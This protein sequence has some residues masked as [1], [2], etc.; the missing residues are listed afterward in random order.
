MIA[1]LV[2]GLPPSLPAGLVPGLAPADAPA[3]SPARA[4]AGLPNIQVLRGLAAVTVLVHHATFYGQFLRGADRPLA[5]LDAMMGLWGV[6]VFFAISGFLMAGLVVRDRPFAFLAHRIV[7][8]FPTYL[9]VV[10]LF[11]GLFAALGL[12]LGGLKPLA[13]SLA[14]AGARS[15]PLNVEWTLV[16]E[17]SFYVGLF[18]VALAGLAHRIV[19]LAL[20]WLGLIAAAALLLPRGSI[21]LT[22]PPLYALALSGA[23]IPF[24]GGL[25]LPRLIAGGRLRPFLGLLA[26]P[27]GAACLLVET[28]AARWLGGIAAVLLVGAAASGPQMGGSH[29]LSRVALRL[30]DWSY[31]L[32]LVHVPVLWLTASVLP[33]DWSGLAYGVTG[34]AAALGVAALLGPLDVAL[35]RRLRR[36]IDAASPRALRRGLTLYL[37]IFFGCAAWGSAETARNDRQES[38]ARAALAALPPETWASRDLAESALSGRGLALPASLRG[39]L[40]AIEAL[41]PTDIVVSAFVFD[42]ARPKREAM[43]ALFCNGRLAGLDRPRRTRKDLAAR[44]GLDGIARRRT[45]YRM[46]LPLAACPAGAVPL[47]VAVDEDGRMAVLP[48]T[49]GR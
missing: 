33:A 32:Y 12:T 39:E 36:R 7:R 23:C 48:G 37:A 27:L 2:R 43:L 30:G 47:A 11:A 19:P 28:E 42:P 31:V 35:Y 41:S 26:L 15:Y 38:R 6:A 3:A 10:A 9:A 17:T 8:I 40:E 14:P 4:A 44:P 25:L 16:F 34:I 49:A 21:D 13:L 5:G 20:G 1:R 45:G 46:R 18:V 24:A 22:A 29:P